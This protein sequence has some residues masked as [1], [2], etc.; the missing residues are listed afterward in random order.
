[1][2]A[3]NS[4]VILTAGFV[5]AGLTTVDSR[6]TE[7]Q[8]KPLRILVAGKIPKPGQYTMNQGTRLLDAIVKAGGTVQGSTR[9]TLLRWTGKEYGQ[10]RE[11]KLIG[12]AKSE[13]NTVLREKD[14]IIIPNETVSGAK[15]SR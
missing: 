9:V 10:A 3:N 6:A 12:G 14:L 15:K 5:M 13:E 1:M 7:T 4:L 8:S 2:K 11:I